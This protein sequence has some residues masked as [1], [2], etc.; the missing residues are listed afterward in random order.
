MQVLQAEHP[1]EHVARRGGGAGGAVP[2]CCV[3]GYRIQWDV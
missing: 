3:T 1:D 2:H